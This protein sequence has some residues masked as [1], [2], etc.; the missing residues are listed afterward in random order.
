M[1]H[2]FCV[3]AEGNG[4]CVEGCEAK[5]QADCPKPETVPEQQVV[6]HGIVDSYCAVRG[7]A[8]LPDC[9]VLE[10]M[11][12]GRFDVTA[13][14]Y[15]E[16]VRDVNLAI[17]WYQLAHT[18]WKDLK[19][20]ERDSYLAPRESMIL[21]MACGMLQA[22]FHETCYLVGSATESKIFRDVDVRMIMDDG[23]YDR[24]FGT[25]GISPYWEVLC[26]SISAWLSDLTGLPVDFQIQHRSRANAR[27][28]R[29][30]GDKRH[31]L[32]M[33]YRIHLEGDQ[34]PEFLRELPKPDC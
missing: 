9:G 3:G 16:K 19:D 18:E 24:M 7:E 27:Y 6:E 15:L 10:A 8:C 21:D 4:F 22:A 29:K 25:A 17:E 11:R 33:S 23:Q 34:L 12:Q 1:G 14:C 31:P 2:I 30:K 32:G 26:A 5:C 13:P 20:G 28:S